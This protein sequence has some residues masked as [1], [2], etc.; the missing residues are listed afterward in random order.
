[1]DIANTGLEN[2]K[3]VALD[4]LALDKM[5]VRKK[6]LQK[7]MADE[8]SKYEKLLDLMMI[9][10]GYLDRILHKWIKKL[11]NTL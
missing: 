6:N 1:M 2:Y 9:N 4:I 10:L 7:F 5:E 8:H 3:Q 11:Q